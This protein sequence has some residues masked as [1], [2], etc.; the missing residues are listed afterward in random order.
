[1]Q[2]HS[3]TRDIVISTEEKSSQEINTECIVCRAT[4]GDL[5]RLFA[6]ARVSFLGM[7]IL[8]LNLVEMM[9]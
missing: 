8:W 3:I 4:N 6:I 5:L 1:M 9:Y 7:T 2:S